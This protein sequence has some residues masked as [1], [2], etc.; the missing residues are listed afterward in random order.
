MK[1][2]TV[3]TSNQPRHL[4]L[5]NE[6]SKI[7]NKVYAIIESNTIFTGKVNDFYKKSEI[8]QEYFNEVIKAENKFFGNPSFLPKN[9]RPFV[10]KMGDLNNLKIDILNKSLKSDLFIVFGSSFIK[11][12]LVDF[13]VDKKTINIHMGVSPYYR[14]SSCNFWA[15][16][17]SDFDLVGSTIHMLSKGLD[18]GDMLFHA[19]PSFESNPLIIL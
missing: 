2:I 8:M 3:F 5:I 4:G 16:K 11:G 19:L 15:M 10:I 12:N 1:N 18:S 7:S 6:L 13:L 9:V 14:G 17:N